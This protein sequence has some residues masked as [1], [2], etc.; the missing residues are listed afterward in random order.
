MKRVLLIAPVP[1]HPSGTGASARVRHMAESLQSLGHEVH[2]LHVHQKLGTPRAPMEQFWGDRFHEFRGLSPVSWVRRGRR[3]ALRVVA[4]TFHLNLP[5]DS[6]FDPGLTRYVRALL[7]RHSF[8]VVIVSYVFYSKVL[9][10]VPQSVLKVIDTHDVFTDRYRIYRE[11]GQPGEF[12][13]TG[14]EGEQLALDRADV[15]LAIQELDRSHFHSLSRTPVA[16]VGHLAPVPDAAEVGASQPAA[17][18]SAMLFV[19]SDMGINVVGVRW[20]IEHVLPAVRER[21][22]AAELW[23]VGSVCRRIGDGVPGVRLFGFVERVA[24]L[25]ARAAVV[26]NPQRFGT[27]LSIKSIDALRH[28]RPLVTT[29]SGGRGLGDGV[30]TAF[31][32]AESA[33]AFAEHLVGLLQDPDR[34]AE[35]AGRAEDFA[36]RHRERSVQVLAEVMDGVVEPQP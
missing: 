4:K 25:Y 6:Y 30:G 27:G 34:R 22:P 21:V 13:S 35:L 8:D 14:R 33:E 19:G 12:F 36:R 28:G 15:V 16:V 20:F 3:K 9:E 11:N 18:D 31:L 26:V 1:T 32:Q 23:L 2:F 29:P 10:A 7:E 5:V 17:S 24:D